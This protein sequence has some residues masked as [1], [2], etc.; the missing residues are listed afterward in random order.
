MRKSFYL[1]LI[2]LFVPCLLYAQ[3]FYFKPEIRYHSQLTTQK[4]PMYFNAVEWTP[5]GTYY[6]SPVEEKFSLAN[7]F[8][9]GGIVGYNL[10]ESFSLE[11][12]INYFRN[13]Q[14]INHD[15]PDLYTKWL[16][17]SINTTHSVVLIMPFKRSALSARVGGI[18]GLTSLDKTIGLYNWERTYVLRGNVSF[19]YV[20][21][22][23]YDYSFNARLS[24]STGIGV[25]NIFYTPAKGKLTQDG[26]PDS[27]IDNVPAYARDINYVRKLDNQRAGYVGNYGVYVL[28]HD[29][30]SVRLTETLRF[31]S[32]F[33]GIGLKY[34]FKFN[35]KD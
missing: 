1:A 25:D 27:S 23:D 31:N 34:K 5:W 3:G 35:E 13:N 33:F 20:F 6:I 4:S 10:N 18:I 15:G 29:K 32:I 2:I 16:Y 8:S 28:D 22:I 12:G 7:G 21:G 11:T 26:Y 17:N 24:L 30:P 19:G 14:T 9:F